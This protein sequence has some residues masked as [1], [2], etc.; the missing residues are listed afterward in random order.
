MS[1]KA[2]PNYIPFYFFRLFE[3]FGCS[4]FFCYL[5]PLQIFLQF[6]EVTI[7]LLS[8]FFYRV[9]IFNLLI[10]GN[11]CIYNNYD[12]ND[13]ENM[14]LASSTSKQVQSDKEKME[15]ISF[16]VSTTFGMLISIVVYVCL[17]YCH[18]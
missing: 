9:F 2:L 3:F 16:Y 17:Q 8:Y 15:Y 5:S 13:R 6:I 12:L 7:V 1:E 11:T 4:L 14:E 10:H 18:F